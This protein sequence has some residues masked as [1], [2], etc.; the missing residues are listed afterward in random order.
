MTYS[1]MCQQLQPVVRSRIPLV[2][3]E[4]GDEALALALVK[5]IASKCVRN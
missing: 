3:I 1:E 2:A 4:G 5:P